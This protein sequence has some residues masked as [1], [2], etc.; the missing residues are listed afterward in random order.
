LRPLGK[1]L[2]RLKYLIFTY[3]TKN[4]QI[5]RVNLVENLHIGHQNINLILDIGGGRGRVS[6]EEV[7]IQ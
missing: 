7:E 1:I 4:M 6:R 2:S 5:K 3:L